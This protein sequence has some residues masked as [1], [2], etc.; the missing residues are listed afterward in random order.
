MT[1]MKPMKRVMLMLNGGKDS[2]GGHADHDSRDD[3]Q[4]LLRLIILTIRPYPRGS[5]TS[6]VLNTPARDQ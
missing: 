4:K 5:P 1:V 3:A 6:G 2:R